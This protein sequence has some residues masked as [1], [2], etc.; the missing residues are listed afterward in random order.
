M[1]DPSPRVLCEPILDPTWSERVHLD[2]P[3]PQEHLLDPVDH[4]QDDDDDDDDEWEEDQVLALNSSYS[5]RYSNLSLRVAGLVPHSRLWSSPHFHRL[6]R[7]LDFPAP[8]LH[9]SLS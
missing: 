8:R 7:Q 9:L 1:V 6:E 2:I 4:M 3:G 5:A